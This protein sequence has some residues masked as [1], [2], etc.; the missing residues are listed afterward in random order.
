MVMISFII[1]RNI[2]ITT[3]LA[4]KQNLNLSEGKKKEKK[5]MYLHFQII[6]FERNEKEQKEPKRTCLNCPN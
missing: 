2:L 5:K 4:K 1:F 3:G 6:C